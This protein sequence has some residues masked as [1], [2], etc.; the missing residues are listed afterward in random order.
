V[1]QRMSDKTAAED[2]RYGT[3]VAPNLVAV[4]HDHYFNF[5]LDLDVDGP[6]NSFNHDVY[7]AVQLPADSPRRSIYV[8]DRRLAGTEKEAQLSTGHGPSRLRVI[9]EATTNSVGNPSSYEVVIANHARLLLDPKD[10]PTRRAGFLQHDVW[11][12]P[13]AAS[14]R[15]AGGDYIFMSKGD[16]GLP[17]W[18]ARD[19]AI[20]NQ[21]IVMWVNLGMHHLTRAED[22]PVMPTVWHSFRLRPHNFFDRNPAIDLRNDVPAGGAASR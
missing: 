15:Y 1:S 6:A 16:D 8:V 9:N 17:V 10:W 13:F 11:V 19:R 22:L 5:R 4:H 2:T 21:D 14:E 3:L 12:T 20:R 7:R 18:A